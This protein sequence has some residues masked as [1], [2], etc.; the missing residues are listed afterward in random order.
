[1]RKPKPFLK[2]AGGKTQVLRHIHDLIKNID[3]QEKTYYEPFLGGGAVLFSLD[4]NRAVVNDLNKDLINAYIQTKENVDRLIELLREHEEHHKEDPYEYYYEVREMDRKSNFQQMD[5]TKKA[6][7]MIYLNKT[8]YNGLYRVN[9]NGEFNTP[10]GRYENP[11]ITNANNLLAVSKF[12][13]EKSIKFL[14]VDFRE[15][16]QSAQKGDLVYFDPPYD[17]DGTKGFVKYSKNG[18]DR[19]ALKRLRD[20][21]ISLIN[22]G[23]YVIISNHDTETVRKLFLKD[24]SEF[25]Y[26]VIENG[27]QFKVKNIETNRSINS[28]GSSRKTKA[29][30]VLIYGTNLPTSQ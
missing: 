19:E 29:K 14:T 17:Y 23:A 9:S 12:L 18:F 2:W 15:A 30:E 28:I 25:K 10:I 20:T 26:C 13:N 8:C 21:A 11:N 22:R 7:R 16:V 5:K 6:A 24:V 27:E 1:M 4:F 3:L